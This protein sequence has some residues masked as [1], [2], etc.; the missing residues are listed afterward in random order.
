M[1]LKFSNC[2]RASVSTDFPDPLLA[3][4]FS[5]HSGTGG[6]DVNPNKP[7]YQNTGK[8]CAQ[9][10]GTQETAAGDSP[11]QEPPWRRPAPPERRAEREWLSSPTLACS[12]RTVIERTTTYGR[13]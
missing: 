8:L 13:S 12:R 11:H 4:G 2:M 1:R 3:G 6:G 10:Y 9:K 5:L 7:A